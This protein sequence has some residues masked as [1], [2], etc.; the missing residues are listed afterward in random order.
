[1]TNYIMPKR[2]TPDTPKLKEVT[3][4]TFGETTTKAPTRADIR[5]ASADE[6]GIN[7]AIETFAELNEVLYTTDISELAP[8]SPDE[9]DSMATEI[10]IVRKAKDIIEGREAALKKY[11][12]DLIDLKISMMGEDP[13]SNS[14]Y[15][16]SPENGVKLSKEVS[17]GKLTVDVDLLEQVLDEEQ[18]RSVVNHVVVMK[19]TNYPGGKSVEETD[20]YFELNEE[21][22]EKELKLGNIGMEQVVKATTPGKVRS[23]FY[24]RTL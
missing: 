6:S 15:L 21:A 22:L 2:K 18:F 13:S 12:T 7:V 4:P 11:A 9:I 23:A 14:G 24:V 5:R 16:V 1:M 10:V 19:T 20:A 3:E 8:L 17:G